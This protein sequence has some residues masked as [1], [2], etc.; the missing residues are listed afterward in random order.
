MNRRVLI[1]DDD[2]NES[3]RLRRLLE[4]DWGV[5]MVDSGEQGIALVKSSEPFVVV[6]CNLSMS[7]MTGIQTLAAIGHASPH[8]VR[9][10]L[11]DAADQAMAVEALNSGR[12]FRFLSKPVLPEQLHQALDAAIV[13]YR[14]VTLEQELFANTLTAVVKVLTDIL[15]LVDPPAFARASRVSRV[16][17]EL[18]V[19]MRVEHVWEVELA[20]SL[21]QLGCV[22]SHCT[23]AGHRN[24][25]ST[26]QISHDLI[27]HIPRLENVARIVAHQ[28]RRF[29]EGSPSQVGPCES[30]PFG[31]R[32]LKIALDYDELIT[33]GYLPQKALA[34]LGNRTGCYDP[35]VLAALE[36][37]FG[38]EHF[39]EVVEVSVFAVPPQAI[40]ADDVR[41]N[42]GTLLLSKGQEVSRAIRLRLADHARQG[43]M[44]PHVRIQRSASRHTGGTEDLFRINLRAKDASAEDPLS[45]KMEVLLTQ[46]EGAEPLGSGH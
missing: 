29:N 43:H 26:A 39:A 34:I 17:K 33:E 3:S 27:A 7:G 44:P 42:D 36:D 45:Q 10:L 31:A 11:I 46:I 21:S 24:R 8:T 4:R 38:I 5:E 18:A 1:I 20:A 32:I 13:Q 23:A 41:A 6:I 12:I 22:A 25:L 19:H 28:N 2:S 40:L 35:R 14:L 15:S 30:I 16:V 9:L 37:Q